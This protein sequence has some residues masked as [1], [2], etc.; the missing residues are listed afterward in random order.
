MSW[1]QDV[2]QEQSV[3]PR[4]SLALLVVAVSI[5]TAASLASFWRSSTKDLV[6]ELQQT[7]QIS[8]DASASDGITDDGVLEQAELLFIVNEAT[9]TRA[10]LVPESSFGGTELDGNPLGL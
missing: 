5:V 6:R 10:G 3:N 2:K 8:V 4:A 7:G 9:D 1:L